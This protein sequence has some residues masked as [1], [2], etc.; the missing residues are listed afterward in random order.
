MR[1]VWR[2]GGGYRYTFYGLMGWGGLRLRGGGFGFGLGLLGW[3]GSWGGE[4]GGGLVFWG[5]GGGGGRIERKKEG[6]KKNPI[7]PSK[8][9]S[10]RKNHRGV[11]VNHELQ[12]RKRRR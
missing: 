12:H 1:G 7:Q 11:F 10:P 3:G 4:R 8:K 6:E 5:L 2:V 9:T